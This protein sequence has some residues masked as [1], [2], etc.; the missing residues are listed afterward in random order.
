MKGLLSDSSIS[1]LRNPVKYGLCSLGFSNLVDKVSFCTEHSKCYN[2]IRRTYDRDPE[3]ILE[4]KHNMKLDESINIS[5]IWE[6]KIPGW[7]G[8]FPLQMFSP[9]LDILKDPWVRAR[10]LSSH[11]LRIT[12][13]SLEKRNTMKKSLLF[14]N[15]SAKWWMEIGESTKMFC[16]NSGDEGYSLS[17]VIPW[18]TNMI[19]AFVFNIWMIRKSQEKYQNILNMIQVEKLHIIE[20]KIQGFYLAHINFLR[21][22]IWACYPWKLFLPLQSSFYQG[23]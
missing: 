8:V 1:G 4:K 18:D 6:R 20:K 9:Y 13:L 14:R 23:K 2:P 17:C 19:L 22:H 21:G 16:F 15:T 3:A 12:E 11:S 5:G 7:T 10:G